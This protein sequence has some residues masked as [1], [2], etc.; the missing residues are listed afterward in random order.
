MQH[1]AS[2]ALTGLEDLLDDLHWKNVQEPVKQMFLALSKAIR[3]QSAGLRDLDHR[4][5]HFTSKEEVH[6]LLSEKLTQVVSKE[7]GK[8]MLHL[9]DKKVDIKKY[10]KLEQQLE[11]VSS[12]LFLLPSLLLP[13]SPVHVLHQ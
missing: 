1:S 4:C 8:E 10:E 11:L 6:C 7:D 12:L 13:Y 3:I 9:I 2:S 5:D